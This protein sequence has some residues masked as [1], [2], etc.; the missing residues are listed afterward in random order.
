MHLRF[1]SDETSDSNEYSHESYHDFEEE[2]DEDENIYSV[3]Y[4]HQSC[5]EIDATLFHSDW[6][7]RATSRI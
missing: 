5:V 1:F 2:V 4:L 7:D 6:L 3:S